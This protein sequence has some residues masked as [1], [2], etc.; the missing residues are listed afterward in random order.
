M[1]PRANDADTL[2]T[3]RV[4]V[5]G[6]AEHV[7]LDRVPA[8]PRAGEILHLDAPMFLAGGGGGIAFHQM[9]RSDAEVHFFTA[10]GNDEAAD[11]VAQS[12]AATGAQVHAARRD[13][14]QTRDIV[15]ITPDGERT[16]I[17]AGEPL[18]PRIDDALPWDTLATCDAVYFTAQDPA[19]LRAT[20][21]A[22]VLAAT[23]RRREAI[24]NAGVQL[25]L[26]VGS[27]LD[28]REASTR[29]DYA[30]PPRALVMTEGKKGGRIETDEGVTRFTP[31]K[32]EHELVGAYGAGDSFAAALT[33]YVARGLPVEDACVRASTHGAAVLRGLNPLEHQARL[34]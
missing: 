4:A 12:I 17:V 28:A 21:W 9:T 23:A 7:V 26:I 30:V 11:L 3:M 18:H 22:R 20:R 29:A 24:A 10:L 13:A 15:L 16:I 1:I 6:H 14:P 8:L 2:G 32:L 19:V 31:P 33:W 27:A 34:E 25:D 5:I